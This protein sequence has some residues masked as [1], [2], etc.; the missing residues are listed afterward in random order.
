L[1]GG[2]KALFY[3]YKSAQTGCGRSGRSLRGPG[4]FSPPAVE[5]RVA[6]ATTLPALP[7]QVRYPTT[8]QKN[9]L[10]RT[11]RLNLGNSAA[12]LLGLQ[13]KYLKPYAPSPVCYAASDSTTYGAHAIPAHYLLSR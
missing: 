3:I 4:V 8:T 7:G 6:V 10:R 2:H 12:T 11:P 1:L 9:I 5:P 13:L